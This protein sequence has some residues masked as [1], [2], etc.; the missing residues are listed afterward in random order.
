MMLSTGADTL[1]LPPAPAR[2]RSQ[3]E[4]DFERILSENQASLSRL[5]WSYTNTSADREDLLQDI[6]VGLWQALPNFRGQCSER[7]FVYRI[8]HNRALHAL[9]RRQPEIPDNDKVAASEDSAPAADVALARE[10]ETRQLADAVRQLP[11]LYRQVVILV[12]EGLDY[13]EISEILGISKTNVGVRLN[14]ARPLLRDYME[15]HR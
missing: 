13:T 15:G 1:S 3:L 4:A 12:L 9:A 11:L 5:A 8:A 7:T 6:A 2:T 14:R 10:Q